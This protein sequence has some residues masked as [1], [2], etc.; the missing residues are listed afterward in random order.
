M[1][2]DSLVALLDGL[3]LY[4][5]AAVAAGSAAARATMDAPC[6]AS[7]T[8]SGGGTAAAAANEWRELSVSFSA[9]TTMRDTSV[10]LRVQS[11]AVN[12]SS[13]PPSSS[14]DPFSGWVTFDNVTL[15]R[16]TPAPDAAGG[17]VD[18]GAAWTCNHVPAN[19]FNVLREQ[20]GVPVSTP[21]FSY[22]I[23][24]PLNDAITFV[25]FEYVESVRIGGRGGVTSVGSTQ[26]CLLFTTSVKP[27]LG[28]FLHLSPPKV[29]RMQHVNPKA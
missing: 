3:P 2:H 17:C 29:D 18:G 19:F 21:Q 13:S 4:Q 14:T 16:V 8:S 27:Q 28:L 5:P 10:V 9:A 20:Y 23:N 6:N 11:A 22:L 24:G 7:W 26:G 12:S 25:P 1:N 15:T